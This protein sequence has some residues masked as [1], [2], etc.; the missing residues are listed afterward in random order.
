MLR[1]NL[2][3]A[4]IAICLQSCDKTGPIVIVPEVTAQY[5]FE[6]SLDG[7]VVEAGNLEAPGA[8]WVARQ[9]N[10]ASSLG[11]G[12]AEFRIDNLNSN[13]RLW[14]SRVVTL[15]PGIEYSLRVTVDIGSR[16][17]EGTTPWNVVATA[18]PGTEVPAASLTDQGSTFSGTPA[19][20]G[21]EFSERT[22]AIR[23]RS[24]EETGEVAVA[25]GIWGRTQGERVYYMD[26]LR[27]EFVRGTS[28]TSP[29]VTNP[30]N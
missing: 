28:N 8:L 12:S 15:T 5:D 10:V 13:A 19:T 11:Q 18:L 3:I 29:P 25:L 30:V 21:V 6:N 24:H 23:F 20:A 26:N 7:W 4:L 22:F 27:M 16:D 9:S 1:R 14:L 17:Q 2:S